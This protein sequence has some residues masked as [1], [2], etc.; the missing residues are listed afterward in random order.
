MIATSSWQPTAREPDLGTSRPPPPTGSSPLRR[1]STGG[2]STRRQQVRRGDRQRPLRDHHR[3]DAMSHFRTPSWRPCSLPSPWTGVR[4]WGAT[5]TVPAAAPR[6]SRKPPRLRANPHDP[7]RRVDHLERGLRAAAWANDVTEARWLITLGAD[8]NAKDETQQSAG[9]IATSEG[10]L[11]LLRLTLAS[12]GSGRR[13]GQ[14]ERHLPDPGGRARPRPR[15]RRAVAR[16]HQPRPHQ[17]DRLSSDPRGGP[18]QGRHTGIRH[19]RAGSGCRWGRARS[20]L[21]FGGADPRWRCSARS[22]TPVRQGI[23]RPSPPRRDLPIP[24]RTPAGRG[25]R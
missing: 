21:T 20:A 7:F 10:Y 18:G 13:Q 19:D 16:R 5:A 23:P 24:T 4:G 1:P 8:V 9:T 2:S 12:R 25:G 6:A 3:P 17:P 22:G 11:D 14:L 15:R